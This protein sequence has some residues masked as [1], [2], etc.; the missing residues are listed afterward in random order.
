MC[1]DIFLTLPKSMINWFYCMVESIF[2]FRV[3]NYSG[4]WNVEFSRRAPYR[5]KLRRVLRTTSKN[6][7]IMR[8]C[9]VKHW[10]TTDF[11]WKSNGKLRF[12]EISRKSKI[13]IVEKINCVRHVG[14]TSECSSLVKNV[15]WY[16]IDIAK[17]YD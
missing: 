17:I 15:H 14:Y 5:E 13:S 8:R 3:R 12:H 10:K 6:L 4:C 9:A 16:I 11:Q 2:K 7:F 1:N